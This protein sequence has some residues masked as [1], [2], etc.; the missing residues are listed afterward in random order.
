[1]ASEQQYPSALTGG[2][3][4]QEQ[5]A[6]PRFTLLIRAAKLVIDDTREFLCIIRDVSATGVKVRL[7]TPLPDDCHS[8]LVEMSNGDRY[9]VEIVWIEGEHAGLRFLGEVDLEALLDETSGAY[10][11]RQV[12]VR[13]QLDAILHSGGAAVSVAVL[14]MSQRGAK[15]VSD[16]WLLMNEL[17]RIET[18]VMPALYAKVRW[19]SHPHY[20]LLFEQT[21]QLD[22]LARITAPLQAGADLSGKTAIPLAHMPR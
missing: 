8:I 14:D 21:F 1:L 19:R 20:G 7:F 11:K 16:K 22:E 2:R 18:G 10:P 13:V 17:V 15:I 9:P 6:A 12:R 5:R 4:D 3:S